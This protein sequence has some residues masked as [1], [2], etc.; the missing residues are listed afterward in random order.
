MLEFI[1]K[2]LSV[3]LLDIVEVSLGYILSCFFIHKKIQSFYST[4]SKSVDNF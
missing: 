2:E 3:F 1:N 4:R